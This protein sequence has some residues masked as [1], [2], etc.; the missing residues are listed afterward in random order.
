MVKRF[1]GE[2]ER[3]IDKP[4]LS[5]LLPVAK[6]RPAEAALAA[7]DRRAVRDA[8]GAGKQTQR[9]RYLTVR[10]RRLK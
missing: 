2:A 7:A 9:C 4:A 5:R 10:D 1:R 6:Q 3:R 8:N